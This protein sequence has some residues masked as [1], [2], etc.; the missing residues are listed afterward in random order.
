VKFQLFVQQHFAG[1]EDVMTQRLSKLES[2]EHSQTFENLMERTLENRML[3]AK[4]W[5]DV[6]DHGLGVGSI[7]SLQI[8]SRE[9][10]EF[11]IPSS[12]KRGY[13]IDWA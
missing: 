7:L 1:L 12:E 5:L 10:Q 2:R 6:Q 4:N 8:P 11:P 3:Q 13:W 9:M